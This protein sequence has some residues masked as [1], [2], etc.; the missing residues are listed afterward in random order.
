MAFISFL[1]YS[2]LAHRF[3]NGMPISGGNRDTSPYRSPIFL[4]NL[5]QNLNSIDRNR[6][7]CC[8]QGSIGPT[9]GFGSTESGIF[10]RPM[11]YRSTDC[12]AGSV[13]WWIWFHRIRDFRSTDGISNLPILVWVAL[14]SLFSD[15]ASMVGFGANC[16]LADDLNKC[17]QR[18]F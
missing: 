11:G 2:G 9:G 13:D 15:V 5:D 7:V 3:L 6:S 10:G 14:L 12:G 17:F 18:D 1:P 4:S 8:F 16:A